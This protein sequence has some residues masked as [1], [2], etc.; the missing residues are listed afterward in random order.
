M[1][2]NRG[3]GWGSGDQEL[4]DVLRA[5]RREYPAQLSG[6]SR[7]A[8]PSPADE[9]RGRFLVETES[10]AHRVTVDPFRVSVRRVTREKEQ[11]QPGVWEFERIR[12]CRA[13]DP[14]VLT[15]TAGIDHR[16]GVIFRITLLNSDPEPEV[17]TLD[18][19]ERRDIEDQVYQ[20]LLEDGGSALLTHGLSVFTVARRSLAQ[21]HLKWERL[22]SATPGKTLR[23]REAGSGQ[24][25]DLGMLEKIIPLE[26]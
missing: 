10:P 26:V 11:P 21:R 8:A 17:A 12:R 18:G 9:V 3:I 14:L 16:L 5:L 22:L 25:V 13:G 2:E 6:Y 23:V 24:A 4:I 19:L 1:L 15:D 7:T 20:L